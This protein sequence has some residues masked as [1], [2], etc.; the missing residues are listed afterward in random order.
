V[1]R[2]IALDRPAL[3]SLD[4]HGGGLPLADGRERLGQSRSAQGLQRMPGAEPFDAQPISLARRRRGFGRV[5]GLELESRECHQRA[6]QRGRDALLAAQLDGPPRRF[7]GRAGAPLS[8]THPRQQLERARLPG[9]RGGLLGAEPGERPFE[10]DLRCLE[11]AQLDERDRAIDAVARAQAV[12]RRVPTVELGDDLAQLRRRAR[13]VA[14]R[15]VGRRQLGA[16]LENRFGTDLAELQRHRQ[17]LARERL[18]AVE[19]PHS[20]VVRPE[21]VDHL[22]EQRAAVGGEHPAGALDHRL[23]AGDRLFDPALDTERDAEAVLRDHRLAAEVRTVPPAALALET[24][25]GAA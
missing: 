14:A 7:E 9:V 10:L 18:R 16:A 1:L 20:L 8:G 15:R 3:G 19:V 12:P 17:R 6:A 13:E 23:E 25:D 21:A 2:R 11:L 22:R 4:R 24:F 5:S